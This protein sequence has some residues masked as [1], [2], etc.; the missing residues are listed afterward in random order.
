MLFLTSIPFFQW[1]GS[2]IRIAFNVQAL[3]EMGYNVD[4]LTVPIGEAKVIAGVTVH[5]V[6]NP[7]RVK[8]IPIGPSLHKLIFDFL[9]FSRHWAWRFATVMR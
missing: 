4:L 8:N 5:R 7:F 3:A 6:A 9:I 2:S 1:R